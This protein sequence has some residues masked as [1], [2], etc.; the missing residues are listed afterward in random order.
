MNLSLVLVIVALGAGATMA[1]AQP[2]AKVHRIGY[3][4][5]ASGLGPLEEAFRQGLRELGY[6]EGKNVAIE[7]RLAH[8][9]LDRLFD[10]AVELVRF[11]VDIIVTPSTLDAL[12]AQRATRTIPIVMA[13]SGD[14]VGTGLVAS[15][16][17]PGGNVTGLTALSRELSG[18]R[19]ELLKEAVRGLS[20][21]AVLWN[22]ANPDKARDLEETL[23]A[24]GTLG[25]QIQ[26]LEVRVG[27]DLE[28][29]FRAAKSKRA[30]ALFTLA[31]TLTIAHQSRIVDLATKGGLP[32]LFQTRDF[33]D[34]GGL[35][36]YGPSDA[37][38]YRRAATYV[39]KILRGSKPGD[40]P[41]EQPK[42]F[43]LIINLKTAKKIG[44]T[45]PPEIL[46]RADK[47]IR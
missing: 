32:T 27:N 33:V 37:D 7:Y 44:L 14:A 3:L 12:A 24:A 21:V 28:S 2:P 41:V 34:A 47:V 1:G 4:T 10:L 5:S 11:K 45:V 38:L 19:L 8:G 6:V 23:V 9:K 42:R 25:L 46:V 26:S 35:M 36:C 16:A 29:A 13:A 18:K 43:D 31:D 30:G 39:D 20:R 17:R 15:L 40:L 22:A